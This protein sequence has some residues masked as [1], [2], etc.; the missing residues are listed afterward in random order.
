VTELS[1]K[2]QNQREGVCASERQ[3]NYAG[4]PICNSSTANLSVYIKLEVR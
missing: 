2:V 1:Y 3:N 4:L